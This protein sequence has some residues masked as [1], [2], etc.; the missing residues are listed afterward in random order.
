[1]DKRAHWQT[2]YSTRRPHEVSWT[3]D[4]PKTSLDFIAGFQLKKSARIIDVGGGD[5]RL[6]DWLLDAG[7]ENLTVL[8]ISAAALEKAQL[9]LGERAKKV[10]WIVDDV[11]NFQPGET[12]DV[13]HDRAT[14]HFMTTDEQVKKYISTAAHATSRFL[15]MAT[16]SETGPEKC[17]GLDVQRYSEQTL[18]RV[19]YG[20]F[21]KIRCLTEDH[22]TPFNVKQ[23]FTFCSFRKI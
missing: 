6:T 13:W 9:R 19:L 15:L 1:M 11:L 14:F 20:G 17:S 10:R 12:Y 16:F 4:V 8:D 7:F 18:T 3:Q 5:S 21:D 22:V 2:I 23:N